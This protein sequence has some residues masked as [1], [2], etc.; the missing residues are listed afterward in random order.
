V[1][2]KPQK[3]VSGEP[4]PDKE[5][6][7]NHL[8]TLQVPNNAIYYPPAFLQP[9]VLLHVARP[10]AMMETKPNLVKISSY[11]ISRTHLNFLR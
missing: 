2:V 3:K 11:S 10:I 7:G 8:N 1:L 9:E 6:K 4:V 5:S